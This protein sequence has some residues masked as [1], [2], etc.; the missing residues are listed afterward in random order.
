MNPYSYSFDEL[1]VKDKPYS[2]LVKL[3][4]E[5]VYFLIL[6][7]IKSV[8]SK[9]LFEFLQ[10]NSSATLSVSIFQYL[11]ESYES[12]NSSHL[13]YVSKSLQQISRCLHHGLLLIKDGTFVLHVIL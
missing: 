12:F 11:L 13:D 9:C 2:V 4:K 10:G 8:I 1:L 3:V 5:L 6:K 7:I